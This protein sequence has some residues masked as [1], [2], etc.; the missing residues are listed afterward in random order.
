[1]ILSDFTTVLT[2]VNSFKTQVQGGVGQS[3]GVIAPILQMW[4]L[5][6]VSVTITGKSFMG[7]YA[8]PNGQ[9]LNLVGVDNDVASLIRLRDKINEAFIR[10]GITTDYRIRII[11]GAIGK[12]DEVSLKESTQQIFV[13]YIDQ[14]GIDESESQP[15]A[16][17][18][19]VQF[20]G[21]PESQ[22]T[23]LR[24]RLMAERDITATKKVVAA[25][26]S[27]IA[28]AAT[29]ATKADAQAQVYGWLVDSGGNLNGPSATRPNGWSE[30]DATAKNGRRYRSQEEAYKDPNYINRVKAITFSG[31]P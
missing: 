23:I 20:V 16:F 3:K 30:A 25:Q 19:N 18:Y 6:P 28:P 27:A 4:Y 9:G 24:A 11:W 31:P 14:I 29:P 26:G 7:A 15:Y 10:T 17:D 21:V 8:D 13:G 22:D 5:G 12:R 2:E 1:V